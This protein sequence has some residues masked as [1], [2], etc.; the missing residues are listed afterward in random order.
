MVRTLVATVLGSYNGDISIE[1]KL[2]ELNDQSHANVKI[3]NVG[4]PSKLAE[5]SLH[6]SNHEP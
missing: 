6:E 3:R 4:C 1:L 5:R 2:G